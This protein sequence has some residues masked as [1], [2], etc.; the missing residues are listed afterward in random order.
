MKDETQRLFI[1]NQTRLCTEINETPRI[2]SANSF[3]RQRNY[4]SNSQTLPAE[5]KAKSRINELILH[6]L[7]SETTSYVRNPNPRKQLPS[8]G[9][10]INLGAVDSQMATISINAN[11]ISLVWKCWDKEYLLEFTV[12]EYALK[13]NIIKW[14]LPTVEVQNGES[15]FIFTIRERPKSREIGKGSAGIDLGRI[16]PYVL[17]VINDKGNRVAHYETSGRL[18]QLNKKRERLL[19]EKKHI[20]AKAKQY[21]ALGLDPTILWTELGFKRDKITLLGNVI[22]QQ[23]GSEVTKKLVKHNVNTL[24]VE[25]LRWAVGK[26]YGSRWTHSKQQTAITHALAREGI[27][28]RK[29]NPKNTSQSCHKCGTAITHNS[30]KRTVWCVECKTSFDRDFKAA[31]NIANKAK[32]Y[33]IGNRTIGDSYSSPE[34]VIDLVINHNSDFRNRNNTTFLT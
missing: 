12:P 16:K 1:E 14:S 22:A 25:D 32:H 10:K 34:Q 30:K 9:S 28:T 17:A 3:A 23:I 15:V 11:I 29:V 13:R 7:V 33:P 4:R 27:K 2:G 31:M 21:E 6:K 5:I 24:N 20:L 8:F 26:K 19:V 18:T